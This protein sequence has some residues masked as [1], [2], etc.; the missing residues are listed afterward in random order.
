MFDENN[1]LT[2][3]INKYTKFNFEVLRL[4]SGFFPRYPISP[5]VLKE[6]SIKGGIV[7][8]NRD[9]FAVGLELFS[10]HLGRESRIDTFKYLLFSLS[11]MWK[12]EV[13][14]RYVS[15][16]MK[17]WDVNQI[18]RWHIDYLKKKIE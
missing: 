13:L 2:D 12:R 1:C 11:L 17:Q 9:L 5:E 18:K 3:M 6:I 7:G 16:R 15:E 8:N 14:C 10:N 4:T